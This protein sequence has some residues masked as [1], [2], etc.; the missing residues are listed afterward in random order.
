MYVHTEDDRLPSM[1]TDGDRELRDELARSTA[2]PGWYA[3]V[4]VLNVLAIAA[5]VA[6]VVIPRL[7]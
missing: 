7:T 3:V 6:L 1:E 5:F 2:R 4:I